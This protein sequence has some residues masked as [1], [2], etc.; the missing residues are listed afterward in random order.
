MR[1]YGWRRNPWPGDHDDLK[2]SARMH[3]R[4]IIH[5]AKTAMQEPTEPLKDFTYEDLYGPRP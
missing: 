1:R 3:K 5:E 2:A 4:A